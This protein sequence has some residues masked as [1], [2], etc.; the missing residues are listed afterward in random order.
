MVRV[1][2]VGFA[3]LQR[4]TIADGVPHCLVST[5]MT[6]HRFLEVR[7]GGKQRLSDAACYDENP[8][9]TLRHAIVRS[10][11]DAPRGVVSRFPQTVEE[12][13]E[14]ATPPLAQH[15]WDVFESDV[16]WAHRLDER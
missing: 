6:V 4:P 12:G 16:S 1:L 13:I 15:A 14:V 11:D 7:R 2:G 9:P 3:A 5:G 8:L 10:V